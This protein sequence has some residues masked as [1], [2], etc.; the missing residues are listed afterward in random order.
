MLPPFDPD[1]VIDKNET[2]MIFQTT[3]WDENR[4]ASSPLKK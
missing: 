3:A 2:I 1:K 4:I